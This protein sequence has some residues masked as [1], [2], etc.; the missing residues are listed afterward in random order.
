MKWFKRAV[1][2]I[3]L[4]F[5]GLAMVPVLVSLDSYRPQIEAMV[6]DKLKEPVMLRQLN[7]RVLPL[8]HVLIEG[9]QVGKAGD[10][11]V[12][13]VAVTPDLLS[14]LTSTKVIRSIDIDGLLITQRA[15]DKIP[16]WT[17]ADPKAPP[18]AFKV[19]V[20]EIRLNDASLQLQQK[21]LGPFDAEVGIGEDGLPQRA[22]LSARDGKF[23]AALQPADQNRLRLTVDAR[24]WSLPLGPPMKFD[25]LKVS[26]FAT[27]T[28]LDLRQIESKLYQGKIGGVMEVNWQKG[29]RLKGQL[30]V[31]AVELR[32]LVPLFSPAAKISGRLSAKPLFSGESAKPE[33]IGAAMRLETPFDIRDGVL[34][35]IDLQRAATRLITRETGGETRFDTLSGQFAMDRGTQRITNLKVTSGSLGAE[36]NVTIAP[37]KALSGR[38]N[39][40]VGSALVVPLNLSGTV[41]SPMALPSGASIAGAA[42][43]SVVMPGVGTTVGAKVG[44]WAGGLFGGEKDTR[45]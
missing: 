19:V 22:L 21:K 5:A 20:R 11:T 13:K 42:L 32:E 7:L 28:S 31:D 4:I 40:Q 12:G 10:L 36:G 14:L 8:P 18:A 3:S 41:D 6:S 23:K 29:L 44:N 25:E 35:G 33:Q 39:A 24:D 37:N 43:G 27:P 17:K 30:A 45:K 2:V 9:I 38:I 1:L 15:L 26:G 16:Q 34:Q